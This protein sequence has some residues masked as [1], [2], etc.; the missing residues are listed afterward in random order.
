MKDPTRQGANHTTGQRGITWHFHSVETKQ[1]KK[2]IIE[3]NGS[4]I[5]YGQIVYRNVKEK[6]QDSDHPAHDGKNMTNVINCLMYVYRQAD[7]LH[8]YSEDCFKLEFQGRNCFQRFVILAL[9]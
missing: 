7:Y 4:Q 1:T 8:Q 2:G 3:V 5:H 9:N 6:R